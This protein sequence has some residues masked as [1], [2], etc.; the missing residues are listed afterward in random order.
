MFFSLD[1]PWENAREILDLHSDM[2]SSRS[3]CRRPEKLQC[4]H[5][6]SKFESWCFQGFWSFFK[7]L[8]G[9]NSSGRLVGWVSNTPYT[10]TSWWCRVMAKKRWRH[11]VRNLTIRN[12]DSCRLAFLNFLLWVKE[13][14]GSDCRFGLYIEKLEKAYN[15]CLYTLVLRCGWAVYKNPKDVY[16]NPKD[17]YKIL[18]IF[19]KFLRVF[20]KIM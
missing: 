14:V 17:V 10:N 7:V 1:F 19:I 13:L 6:F 12:R 16:K 9:F 5:F 11:I 18:R 2:F 8:E 4:F 3:D 20:I 15:S